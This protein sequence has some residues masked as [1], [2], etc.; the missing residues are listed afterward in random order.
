MTT[1][2]T[3]LPAEPPVRTAPLFGHNTNLVGVPTAFLA[4]PDFN[5]AP[6]PLHI[7][8]VRD[9]NRSLFT[10]LAE[11]E[12]HA[13]AALAFETYMNAVFGLDPEMRATKKDSEAGRPRRFRSSYFR[14]LRGW[15]F[16]SN[17]PE[18]AVLKGWAE[19]RFGLFPTYHKAPLGRYPSPAWMVYVEEKM[20]SRFHNNAIL[21]QLD[22]LYE[23][24]QW[25]LKNSLQLPQDTVTVYRGVNDFLEH[26]VLEKT[27]K[28]AFLIRLN[29]VVSFTSDRDV[30]SCFGDTILEVR[31]P[32]EKILFF[33]PLLPRHG[34][35]GEDEYLVIGGAYDVRA[36]PY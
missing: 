14:L 20:S 26:P 33:S 13:D 16:D 17:G 4:A 21:S 6:T 18:G 28:R 31:V 25:S 7:A 30:A 11:A 29:N 2:P 27:G 8:G 23:F 10:M 5:E 22:L 9:L 35:K 36:T 3:P 19:S 1:S 15:G 32:L 24:C 12:D 34:L